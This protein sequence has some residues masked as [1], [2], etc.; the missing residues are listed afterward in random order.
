M[1]TYNTNK[2]IIKNTPS[3]IENEAYPCLTNKLFERLM[4]DNPNAKKI[5]YMCEETGDMDEDIRVYTP[6]FIKPELFSLLPKTLVKFNFIA[7]E[8]FNMTD[9]VV[10]HLI[11]CKNLRS[12][13]LNSFYNVT[14]EKLDRLFTGLP[15]ITELSIRFMMYYNKKSNMV[16]N[17]DLLK[18]LGN[19]CKKLRKLE[20][21]ILKKYNITEFHYLPKSIRYL[22]LMGDKI[23]ISLSK[24]NELYESLPELKVFKNHVYRLNRKDMKFI[25]NFRNDSFMD[26]DG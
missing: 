7:N 25:E 22:D 17:N 12:I 26:I 11:Q 5:H 23:R 14:L 13:N 21:F 16:M 9:E 6:K 15:N 19:K 1:S 10:D 20:M 2:T 4:K 3:D 24:L 18:L 8:N